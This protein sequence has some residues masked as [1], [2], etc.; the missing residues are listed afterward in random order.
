MVPATCRGNELVKAREQFVI[1]VADDEL[2]I[3]ARSHDKSRLF[4]LLPVSWTPR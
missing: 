1:D 4:G 3:A 2:K